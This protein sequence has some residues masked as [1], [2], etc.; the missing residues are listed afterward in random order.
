[1]CPNCG[2]APEIVEGFPSFAPRLALSND[3]VPQ[4]AHDF[5]DAVQD[6]SFWF[7]SRNRLIQ[8]LVRRHFRDARDVLE[9]GCGSGFVLAGLRAALPNARLVGS[10]A[11]S[12]G[13]SYAAQ[14]VS[15]PCEF[16]QM[17]ACALPYSEAFDLIGAFDVLEHL[18]DDA[19]A[20]AEIARALRPG[21]GLL[22]TVPQHRWLWSQ[23]DDIS[24]HRRRYPRGGIAQLLRAQGLEVLRETSFMCLLLP[25]MLAQ[26]LGP[27][28]RRS[29]NAKAEFALP[30]AVQRGLEAVLGIERELIFSGI[31]LPI[32]GSQVVV[33]RK[34]GARS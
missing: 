29:Y 13:L 20:V 17:D 31:R 21:G 19:A 22:V 3:G 33:A 6:R 11:Y 18:D 4:G 14:R 16:L 5:L 2:Y 28:R 27:G 25:L 15:P 12:S 30:A 10:E 34:R 32:G 8:G 24:H 1:V 9:I 23:V 7:R 26:R